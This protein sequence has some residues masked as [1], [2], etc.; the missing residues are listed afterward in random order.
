MM[1]WCAKCN[2]DLVLGRIKYRR[3]EVWAE[4][5][6]LFNGSRAWARREGWSVVKVFVMEEMRAPRKRKP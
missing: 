3:R 4:I 2:G 5:E 6:R 1:M